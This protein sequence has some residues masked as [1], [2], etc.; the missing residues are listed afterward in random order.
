MDEIKSVAPF[1]ICRIPP[2]PTV[3]THYLNHGTIKFMKQRKVITFMIVV[4]IG[5]TAW[6]PWITEDYARTAVVESLGG[7]DAQ[8][9]YLGENVT[10]SEIPIRTVRVPF[11]ILVYFPSEAMFI[12]TFWGAVI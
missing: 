12:V 11:A 2:K 1:E 9:F 7:E 8:Y 3:R 6:A 5:V 4:L 10:I